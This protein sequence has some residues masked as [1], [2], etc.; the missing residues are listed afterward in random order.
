MGM[1]VEFNTMIV[2]K[3]KEQR[4]AENTFQLTKDGFRIYPIDIPIEVRKTKTG[5]V[6]GEAIVEKL[7]LSEN[8][9]MITYK[10]INLN[11]TN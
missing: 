2:T 6:T 10:L 1:P 8:Q 7:Q 4:I 9:T 5:E 11:S 3:G